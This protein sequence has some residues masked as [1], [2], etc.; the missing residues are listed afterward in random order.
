MGLNPNVQEE[1]RTALANHFTGVKCPS[2]EEI[3]HADIPYL[4]AVCEESIRLSGTASGA[5]R[6]AVV[7]TEVLGHRIPKGSEIL[8]NLL[9]NYPPIPVDESKRNS[10]SKAAL[11]K[12]NYHASMGIGPGLDKFEPGRWLTDDPKTAKLMF[13]PYARPSIGFG[14][15]YRGCFGT[16]FTPHIVLS[17]QLYHYS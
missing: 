16:S 3:I 11:A 13:R 2:V 5:L 10:S 1:L 6:Q 14:G 7:D 9:Y 8:L 15:G 17:S 4:D 12:Q